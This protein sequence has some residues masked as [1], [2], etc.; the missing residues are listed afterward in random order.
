MT[1]NAREIWLRQHL[2][3]LL[4]TTAVLILLQWQAASLYEHALLPQLA[5]RY[6]DPDDD[7]DR[8]SLL[9]NATAGSHITLLA[10]SGWCALLVGRLPASLTSRMA[11]VSALWVLA[12]DTLAPFAYGDIWPVAMVLTAMAAVTWRW[13]NNTILNTTQAI[14]SIWRYP[15][16]VLLTGIGVLWLT[17]Y[18]ARAY[19]K[20]QYVGLAHTDAL[21]CG[22]AVLSLCAAAQQ[23]WMAVLC[24]L[25]SREHAEKCAW[26]GLTLW[27]CAIG[28]VSEFGVLGKTFTNLTGVKLLPALTTELIRAPLFLAAGWISYRWVGT[29]ERAGLGLVQLA[30]CGLLWVFAQTLARD[31]GPILVFAAA[32]G[33]ML[34]ALSG[35][36]LARVMGTAA[37]LPAV[38]IAGGVTWGM[39][40][41]L[42]K[43]GPLVSDTLARRIAALNAADQVTSQFLSE[44]RWF[45]AGTPP[46][47]HG[48][49]ATPWCGDWAW[50]ADCTS[51]VH[52]GVPQQTQSDYVF[53]ALAGVFGSSGALLIT[54]LLTAWLVALIHHRREAAN[55]ESPISSISRLRDSIVAVFAIVTLM[56]LAITVFGTLGVIPLT[57]VAFPLVGYGR[58]A[59][60]VTCIF[61]AFA[62]NRETRK[63]S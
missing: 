34:A 31:H 19:G 57:G 25:L 41:A 27:C 42:L 53:A 60:I 8:R 47:G 1:Y 29:R 49:G 38:V 5:E 46:F 58:A 15:A 23:Q 7:H 48:L 32:S 52:A 40:A 55:T 63:A 18:S 36:G 44:L 22:Y 12:A 59:L 54:T 50:L 11:L 37:I 14:D 20:F 24:R 45:M 43:F 39:Y 62:I 3:E 16:F 28:S 51:G 2:L 33:I 35:W 21:F 6:G 26:A 10:L 56:Q 13:G 30:S 17:D 9:L 4:F 61:T